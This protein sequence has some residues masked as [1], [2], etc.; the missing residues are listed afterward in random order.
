[1]S[2]HVG[3]ANHFNR[4]PTKDQTDILNQMGLMDVINSSFQ[5]VGSKSGDRHDPERSPNQ[6]HKNNNQHRTGTISSSRLNGFIGAKLGDPMDVCI[7]L[8]G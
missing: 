4:R 6:T 1:M 5:I 3:C 8:W 2:R 7:L